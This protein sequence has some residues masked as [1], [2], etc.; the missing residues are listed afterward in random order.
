MTVR[1]IVKFKARALVTKLVKEG[2]LQ[3]QPCIKCGNPK[4]HGHHPDY[5]FPDQVI[6]LCAFHHAREH[7]DRTAIERAPRNAKPRKF[8]FHQ[9][10]SERTMKAR[11]MITQGMRNADIAR[12][13][14]CSKTRI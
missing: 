4:S 2:K 1:P 5:N 12:S 11:E 13:L 10:W 9:P 3:R 14:G 7:A 6:W 8:R